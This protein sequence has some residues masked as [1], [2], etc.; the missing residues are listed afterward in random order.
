MRQPIVAAVILAIGA[1]TFH[2]AYGQTVR[3]TVVNEAA[4][5]MSGVLVQLLDSNSAVT[6]HTLSG[7]SGEFRLAA[8]R[9]GTFR[10][11]TLRIGFRPA[12]SEPLVLAA[13]SEVTRR[14][15]LNGVPIALDTVR[16]S[17]RSVCRSFGDSAAMAYVVWD[18]ARAALAATQLTAES[19]GVFTRTVAYQRALDP[20]GRR[21]RSDSSEIRSGYMRQ[22]WLSLTPD[23]L[24]RV[25]YV[26]ADGQDATVYYAPG[27]DVLLSPVFVEDHCFHLVGDEKRIGIAFEPAPNRRR[28]PEIRGTLWV[29]RATA[30]LQELEFGYVNVFPELE[31]NARGAM[32]FARMADGA[33]AIAAWNIRM[34]VMRTNVRSQ[35]Y[36]G[37]DVDVTEI[38][39]AGGELALA[40]R[41][42]DTL[43]A[44]ERM[45]LS[46]SVVDSTSGAR[47]PGARL[48]FV[49]TSLKAL[50]DSQGRFELTGALPGEYQLEVHTPSLD[51][52]SAAYQ[53]SITLADSTRSIV[54]R[55]PAAKEIA[56]MFCGEPGFGKGGV[57]LGRV[58]RFGDSTIE[59]AGGAT[60]VADWKTQSVRGNGPVVGTTSTP[61]S[62]STR[63]DPHG[64][65]RLCGLP[66]D[67]RLTV[68]ASTSGASTKPMDVTIP[69]SGRF[70]RADLMLDASLVPTATF[71]GIVV[72]DST[73]EPVVAAEVAV[74]ALGLS[75]LSDEHGVFRLSGI[76]AGVQQVIV[77]RIGY[78]PMEAQ[79]T[80]AAGQSVRRTVRPGRAVT[81]DS[82]IVTESSIDKRMW[83]FDENRRLGLGHFFTREDLSKLENGPSTAAILESIPGLGVERSK[84]GDRSWIKGSRGT[85]KVSPDQFSRGLGASKA[86]YAQVYLDDVLIYAARDGEDLFDVNSIPVSEIEAIE[87]YASPAETPARYNGLNSTCGVLVI[88]TL[89]SH[90][91]ADTTAASRKSPALAP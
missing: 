16:V 58:S 87:Y 75:T 63:A 84:I 4:A 88:W 5:P 50:A 42:P 13:G 46:G 66:L 53:S 62:L 1:A 85:R 80:F 15:E 52:V 11:R 24:R 60:V 70:A 32:R 22:P 10:V 31:R 9:T 89:R 86:C 27:L 69:P 18:Q 25:G 79:L 76:T 43:W 33:W 7:V 38:D 67:T 41:G 74:P 57:V 8:P 12:V 39:V 78:G 54:V 49:G 34:P 64:I 19:R 21:V 90:G 71:A 37:P 82:V 91:K 59:N 40:M 48:M 83:T 65:F 6:A 29:E 35:R 77:R 73:S 20:D 36:G 56:A 26:V 51:S 81:L 23:S 3:G 30:A 2:A 44:H 45:A 17:G 14:L 68:S 72:L 55:V 47:I 61:H 28:T